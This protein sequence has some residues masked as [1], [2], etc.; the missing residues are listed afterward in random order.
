VPFSI[1]TRLH[2][3]H[4]GTKSHSV[5][6]QQPPTMTGRPRAASVMPRSTFVEQ[7]HESSY[8][9]DDSIHRAEYFSNAA[10]EDSYNQAVSSRGRDME[11]LRHANATIDEARQMPNLYMG[12]GQWAPSS[13]Y[14]DLLSQNQSPVNHE[15][16]Y[17][18]PL[19]DTEGLRASNPPIRSQYPQ[20]DAEL[21][22][23]TGNQESQNQNQKSL[24]NSIKGSVNVPHYYA[25]GGDPMHPPVSELRRKLRRTVCRSKGQPNYYRLKD[26]VALD[27]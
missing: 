25:C 7:S 26:N 8:A 2:H 9:V 11:L 14:G 24:D 16:V 1:F 12:G 27:Q 4:L 3:S 13:H 15:G 23:E 17:F 6:K 5:L 19:V 21:Y 18:R 22:P 10:L 20:Y